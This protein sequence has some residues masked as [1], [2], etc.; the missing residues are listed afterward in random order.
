MP[1]GGRTHAFRHIIA[2][3]LVKNYPID[4][5]SRAA[6]ALHNTVKM[7]RDY[8]GHLSGL[9]RTRRS[10]LILSE[11]YDRAPRTPRAA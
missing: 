11:E 3:H 9:D 4:G 8:Y 2:T 10:M 1:R 6:D 5:F 7:I